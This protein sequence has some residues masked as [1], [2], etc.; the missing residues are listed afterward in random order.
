MKRLVLSLCLSVALITPCVQAKTMDALVLK[1]SLNDSDGLITLG[2]VFDN[3]GDKSEVV[4]ARRQGTSHIFDANR[5]S[6]IA[7]SLGHYWDN[8]RGLRQVIVRGQTNATSES[9][10]PISAPSALVISQNAPNIAAQQSRQRV[11]VFARQM[12]A[13]EIVSHADLELAYVD[14]FLPTSALCDHIEACLGKTMRWPIR[15]GGLA[16]LMDVTTPAMVRRSQPVQV[17]WRMPGM[18]LNLIGIAQ[19]DAAMG[20]V[21]RIQNTQSKKIIEAVVT[22]AGRAEILT[23]SSVSPSIIAAR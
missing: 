6:A 12:Q 7:Q 4:I 10:A 11:L 2:E 14:N 3:A 21:V 20:E 15:K 23:P 22:A 17:S 8:P 19:N 9:S 13:G 18:S 1:P 16:R 5:L